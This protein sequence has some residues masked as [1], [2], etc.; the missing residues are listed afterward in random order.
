MA[1]TP[2]DLTT[3]LSAVNTILA[4]AGEQPV[5]SLD[6]V[7]SSLAEVAHN[8]LKE[9]SRTLQTKGW[10]WNREDDYPLSLNSESELSLPANTL[11]VHEVRGSTTKD[12]VQRGQRLYDRTNH[13]FTFE[14]SDSIKVNV[15]LFLP[16]DLLPEFAKQPILYLAQRRFQMRELTSQAI[17]K[18]VKEDVEAATVL[19]EQ[20]EDEQG[21]A[22]ILSSNPT[23][24]SPGNIR[25]RPY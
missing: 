19:L 2:P 4:G 22:N 14:A 20:A 16:W 6:E 21:P 18:A 9:S 8:A 12:C 7:E 10:Y 23:L 1:S 15:T 11:K 5:S 24:V 17:D 3:E 25:R 13:T